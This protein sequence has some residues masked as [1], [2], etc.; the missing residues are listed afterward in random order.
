MLE[1]RGIIPSV[2]ECTRKVENL[3]GIFKHKYAF[4]DVIYFLK[5]KEM[6]LSKESI[7]LRLYKEGGLAG[8][9]IILT[10]RKSELHEGSRVEVLLVKKGFDD[11]N[12][13]KAFIDIHYENKAHPMFKYFRTGQMY[14]I[15]NVKLYIEQIERF[16][17]SIAAQASNISAISD[18]FKALKI[19]KKITEP[20]PE[21]MRKIMK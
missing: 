13:A 3:G 11:F 2:E 7:R 18:I 5:D 14:E 21:F 17:P 10:H 8:R 20:V 4:T 15:G 6:D 1:A 9:N 16:S 19:T 12:E